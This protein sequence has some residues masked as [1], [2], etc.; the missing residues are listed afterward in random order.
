MLSAEAK[1][2]EQSC[3]CLGETLDEIGEH[4][5]RRE[6]L[7]PARK[8]HKTKHPTG[9]RPALRPN[10]VAEKRLS[11]DELDRTGSHSANSLTP[12]GAGERLSDGREQSAACHPID[13]SRV[14]G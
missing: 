12:I 2:R 9:I 5:G 13:R 4:A 11:E 6:V 10:A 14:S 7:S 3:Q 8:L 1:A